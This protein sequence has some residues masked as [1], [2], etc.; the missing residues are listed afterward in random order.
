[1][2]MNHGQFLVHDAHMMLR[3]GQ[4][5]VSTGAVI[6]E[7]LANWITWRDAPT[8]TIHSSSC[9]TGRMFVQPGPFLNRNFSARK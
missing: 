6:F 2:M 4:K 8:P 1:M 5:S 7:N 3:N 9:L